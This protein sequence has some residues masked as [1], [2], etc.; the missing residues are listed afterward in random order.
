M[1]SGTENK[2]Q[3]GLGMFYGFIE[4]VGGAAI[5]GLVLE[6]IKGK[7][8]NADY[9]K[10]LVADVIA[11]G[12]G[13]IGASQLRGNIADIANGIALGAVSHAGSQ[14]FWALEATQTQAKQKAGSYRV[15]SMYSYRARPVYSAVPTLAI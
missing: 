4:N 13:M 9:K 7:S 14:L 12:V 15:G 3:G 8:L 1:S 11:A 6:Y 5:A 2:M 10:A